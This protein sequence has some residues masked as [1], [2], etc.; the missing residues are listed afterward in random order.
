MLSFS[1]KGNK[2]ILHTGSCK[3]VNKV[4]PFDKI[5]QI[6][7]KRSDDNKYNIACS[8]GREILVTEVIDKAFASSF[9][10]KMSDWIS[11][12]KVINDGS[13]VII[14]AHNLVALLQVNGGK[15][16][17][18]QKLRCGENSTLYCS[19]IHG[20]TWDELVFF[21]GSA[22]GEL[23]VWKKRENETQIIH[24]QFLHNGVIFSIDYNENYLVSCG[25]D[26]CN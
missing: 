12:I 6:S 26:L 3:H 13:V 10:I 2:L 4:S 8:A 11:S 21:S 20:S 9:V 25:N 18:K 24:R 14:T 17:V 22:L 16:V 7:F 1:A 23:I 19:H 15:A 5:H